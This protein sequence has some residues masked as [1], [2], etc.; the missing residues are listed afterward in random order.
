MI[1]NADNS[2]TRAKEIILSWY[3]LKLL[4]AAEVN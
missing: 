4:S 2:I 3:E 1:L